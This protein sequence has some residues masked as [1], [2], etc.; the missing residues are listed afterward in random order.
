MA[1]GRGAYQVL[2]GKPEGKKSLGRC[3]C[4]WEDNIKI[5][6]QDV[7]WEKMDWIGLVEDRDRY[8]N[9]FLG[10]VKCGHFLE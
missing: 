4:K 9:E 5:H 7:G 2:V 6:L 3:R 10:S 1:G 8:G